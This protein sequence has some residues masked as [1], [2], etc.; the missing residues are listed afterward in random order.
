ML[1][2]FFSQ[3]F[4]KIILLKDISGWGYR[5]EVIQVK[6]KHA[7]LEFIR[8]LYGVYFYPGRRELMFPE[9]DQDEIDKKKE[10]SQFDKLILKIKETPPIVA[11][12]GGHLDGWLI[13]S[14][15]NQKF[16]MQRV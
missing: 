9:Y 3:T 14:W 10:K 5:G 6:P 8:K 7:Q 2:R 4:Q 1:K 15:N 12:I 13:S 16:K 11:K